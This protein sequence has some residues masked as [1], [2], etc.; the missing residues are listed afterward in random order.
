MLFNPIQLCQYGLLLLGIR[1]QDQMRLTMQRKIAIFR[2]HFGSA[3]S[4]LADVWSDLVS[5]NVQEFKLTEKEMPY[6]GLKMF[7][8]ANFELWIY[9]K[10]AELI[11]TRFD[12]CETYSRGRH[13]WKWIHRIQALKALKIQWMDS[14]NDPNAEEFIITIDGTDCR[15]WEKQHELFPVDRQLCSSKFNHA[16]FKYE[17]AL[18]IRHNKIVWVN[19][20]YKAGGMHD[21]TLFREE[22]LKDMMLATE[23]KMAIVDRGYTTSKADEVLLLAFPN[24]ADS[25]ELALFKSRARARHETLNGRLKMFNI[26]SETFRHAG[27]KHKVAFEAVCVLVQY[28]LDNGAFLFD[29]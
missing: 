21:L 10:N 3:P 23:N 20:P 24:K 19:G 26:L 6:K 14:F 9:P 29:V 18:A 4:D 2:S 5:T 7:L 17:I 16:A 27:D 11:M 12:I 1:Q 8:I 28:Q 13:L 22:G 15:I 25:K